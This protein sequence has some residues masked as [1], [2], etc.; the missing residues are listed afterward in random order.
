MSLELLLTNFYKKFIEFPEHS[1]QRFLP[2]YNYGRQSR[3]VVDFGL[4]W[5]SNRIHPAYSSSMYIVPL[6]LFD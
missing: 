6:N 1:M 4:S 3:V 5:I 2:L